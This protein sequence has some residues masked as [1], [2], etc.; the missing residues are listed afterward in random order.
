MSSTTIKFNPFKS[1][2]SYFLSAISVIMSLLIIGNPAN[3]QPYVAENVTTETT[4]ITVMAENKTF[5]NVGDP[6]VRSIEKLQDGQWVTVGAYNDFTDDY[7]TYSVFS[8][9]KETVSFFG[10]G[11][12]KTLPEGEYRVVI[13]FRL[14]GKRSDNK[15]QTAYAYFTV[16][17]P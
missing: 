9:F 14:E 2:L 1:I 7:T 6:R 16:T 17:E 5:N 13:T 15:M 4:K 3:F 11:I 10:M 12:D 8:T